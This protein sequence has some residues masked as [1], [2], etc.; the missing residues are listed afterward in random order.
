[1]KLLLVH[2][3]FGAIKGLSHIG[4]GVAALNTSLTL[5]KAGF[6]VDTLAITD[7]NQLRQAIRLSRNVT[8]VVISA[9]WILPVH[10]KTLCLTF[11]KIQFVMNCHSNV[12]FL[13]ADPNGTRILRESFNLAPNFHISANSFKMSKWIEAAYGIKA[14]FLPN[15]YYL[16]REKPKP[17]KMGD[18]LNIGIFGAIRPLKNIVSAAGAAIVISRRLNKPTRIHLST[19]RLEGGSQTIMRSVQA[20][21]ADT[22]VELV[23]SGWAPWSEFVRLVDQMHLL[24]QPSYTESF[25]MVTAD[26]ISQGVP[27][28]VSEAI[29]WAPSSWK[30]NIDDV[31][32]MADVGLK[33]L[34]RKHIAGLGWKALHKYT[35]DGII[36]W[37]EFLNDRH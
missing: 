4:L 1:M 37:K 36:H 30:A 32:D 2:K 23:P 31:V 24:L 10:M 5:R 13:M 3:N 26:G 14:L 34:K 6:D 28:V 9:P 18:V 22:R 8:H 17:K 29:N 12:G 27:S 7:P 15:L 19:G 11:P 16:H 33:L 20:L 25:N 35:D 21:I